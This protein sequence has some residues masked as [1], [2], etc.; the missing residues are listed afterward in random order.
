M[1]LVIGAIGY[2]LFTRPGAPIPLLTGRA[3]PAPSAAA[4]AAPRFVTV[5]PPSP[6]KLGSII[7]VSGQGLDPHKRANVGILVSGAVNPLSGGIAVQP[8]GSFSVDGLVP[9]DLPPGAA[10]VVACNLDSQNRSDLSQC[11]QLNVTLVR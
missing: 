7:T 9:S 6:L 3:L 4:S 5:N 10:A 8:D 11:I 2:W 1:L